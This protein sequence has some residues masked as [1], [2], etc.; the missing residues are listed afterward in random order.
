MTMYNGYT[1]EELLVEALHSRDPLVVALAGR[2][3]DAIDEIEYFK[4]E[5]DNEREGM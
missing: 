3:A 1:N 2:L 5:L 4:E